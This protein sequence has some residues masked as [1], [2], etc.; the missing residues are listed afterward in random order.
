MARKTTRLRGHVRRLAR[1]VDR[2][3]SRGVKGLKGAA[4]ETLGFYDATVGRVLGA[5]SEILHG[6]VR[7]PAQRGTYHVSLYP[8]SIGGGYHVEIRTPDGQ[9]E[10]RVLSNV[11]AAKNFIE[12]RYRS[13][14]G[15]YDVLP[16]LVWK[17]NKQHWGYYTTTFKVPAKKGATVNP[18]SDIPPETIRQF[19]T[20]A[21]QMLT[22]AGYH[23]AHGETRAPQAR[24]TGK[25]FIYTRPGHAEIWVSSSLNWTAYRLGRGLSGIG[26]ERMEAIGSSP[27]LSDLRSALERT[28]HNPDGGWEGDMDDLES[29]SEPTEVVESE[30]PVF[31]ESPEVQFT[32]PDFITYEE[33]GQA[34]AYAQ[35]IKGTYPDVGVTCRVQD[36]GYGR[37]G[38][39]L[40]ADRVRQDEAEAVAVAASTG[41]GG[42]R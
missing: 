6:A 29:K 28:K 7:N 30:V 2:A 1:V 11:D 35:A 31:R 21:H 36:Q 41:G 14:H 3:T 33:L 26:Q 40:H 25:A 10:T 38:V 12:S 22:R 34:L 37:Y 27:R 15:T 5:P 20:A 16:R 18:E 4:R 39:V 8:Q 24:T 17:P 19:L 32:E 23:R 13:M 9:Y 42:P